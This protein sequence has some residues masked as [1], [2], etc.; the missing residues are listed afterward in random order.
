M[1]WARN[2]GA[3]GKKYR[4]AIGTLILDLQGHE[5]DRKEQDWNPQDL[6]DGSEHF[7]S[8]VESL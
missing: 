5:G 3:T 2:Q 7:P 6:A 4:G 8:S 1:Q